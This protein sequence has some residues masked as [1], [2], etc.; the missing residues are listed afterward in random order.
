MYFFFLYA[1]PLVEKLF[2][3]V[4]SI[5]EQEVIMKYFQYSNY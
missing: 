2:W 5:D 4:T 1:H 3:S